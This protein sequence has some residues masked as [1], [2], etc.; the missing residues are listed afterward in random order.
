[1][2]FKALPGAKGDVWLAGGASDGAYGLWHSTDGGA[3]FTK[4]SPPPPSGR[5]LF[6]EP[7]PVTTV[8]SP[9][10]HGPYSFLTCPI[11]VIPP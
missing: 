10:F 8:S 5:T 6:V 7:S 3:S 11:T 4:L 2:R 1:M 9:K